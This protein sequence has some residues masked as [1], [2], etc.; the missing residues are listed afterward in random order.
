MDVIKQPHLPQNFLPNRLLHKR[1]L[2]RK[3]NKDIG[4]KVS[5]ISK[6]LSYLCIEKEE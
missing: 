6:T 3:F 4:E 5:K 1:K 2:Q